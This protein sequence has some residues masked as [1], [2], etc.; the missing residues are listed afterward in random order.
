LKFGKGDK[1]TIKN[2]RP[3]RFFTGEN[4][5]EE[6]E[7]DYPE[8][9]TFEVDGIEY[10]TGEIHILNING[11]NSVIGACKKDELN[12]YGLSSL[13]DILHDYLMNLRSSYT[14]DSLNALTKEFKSILDYFEIPTNIE[15]YDFVYCPILGWYNA[16]HKESG[17]VITCFPS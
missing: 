9:K 5:V 2:I 14:W 10:V 8:L 11:Y 4:K 13:E 3:N 15:D 17:I 12:E 7:T 16:T 6:W 1:M